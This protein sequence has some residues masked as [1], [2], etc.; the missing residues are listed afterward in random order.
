MQFVNLT[1]HSI[2]VV[3]DGGELEIPPSG[4]VA[5]V[6]VKQKLVGNI[7]GIPLVRNEW[8]SIEGLPEPKDG[9]VYIVSSL[10]LSRIR[11]RT[12]VVAPDTGPSAIRDNKGRITGIRRFVLPEE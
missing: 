6:A 10:V 5:R 4:T 11:G 2:R 9:I 8:G 1:P 12:D 3:L 7:D